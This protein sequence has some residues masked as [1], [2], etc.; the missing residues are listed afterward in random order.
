MQYRKLGNTGIQIS[1]LSLGSWITFGKQIED[2]ISEKL[3]SVAY[4]AGTNFFDDAEIYVRGQSEIVMGK[5]LT[6]LNWPRSS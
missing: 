3:M 2:N 4:D 1:A 6:N 5:A